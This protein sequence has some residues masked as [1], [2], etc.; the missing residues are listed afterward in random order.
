MSLLV[1]FPLVPHPWDAGPQPRLCAVFLDKLLEPDGMN[2]PTVLVLGSDKQRQY[3]QFTAPAATWAAQS[4]TMLSLVNTGIPGHVPVQSVAPVDPRVPD[5][6]RLRFS[7]LDGLLLLYFEAI[8]GTFDRAYGLRLDGSGATEVRTLPTAH[9][10]RL[11]KTWF[12]E[13]SAAYAAVAKPY[14][15]KE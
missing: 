15:G 2:P 14:T 3:V 6:W 12:V 5:P 7:V 8:D 10:L 11:P 13:V 1:N 4:K 9:S